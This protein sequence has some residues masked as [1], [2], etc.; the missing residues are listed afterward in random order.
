MRYFGL[1]AEDLYE[2][3]DQEAALAILRHTVSVCDEQDI[4]TPEVFAVLSALEARATRRGA[5]RQFRAALSF[6]NPRA[7][8]DAA[9]RAFAGIVKVLGLAVRGIDA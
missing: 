3:Q 6:P 5:F 9:R 7:R 4:R 8:Q 2:R 1:W